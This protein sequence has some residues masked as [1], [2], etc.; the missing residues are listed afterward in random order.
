VDG[1]GSNGW[2]MWL[3]CRTTLLNSSSSAIS[4]SSSNVSKN[5][6][7]YTRRRARSISVEALPSGD[8]APVKLVTDAM[9]AIVRNI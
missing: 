3:E 8:V 2:S 7:Q 9:S 6:D 4:H 1:G 5:G